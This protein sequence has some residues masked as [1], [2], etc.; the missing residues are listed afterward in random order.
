MRSFDNAHE[1]LQCRSLVSGETEIQL[2]LYICK[3]DVL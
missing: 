2:L 3:E 1:D